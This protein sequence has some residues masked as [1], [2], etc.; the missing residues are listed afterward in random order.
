[1]YYLTAKSHVTCKSQ[2]YSAM[3]SCKVPPRHL[4]CS[5]LGESVCRS[6]SRITLQLDSLTIENRVTLIV[7]IHITA[8]RVIIG[9]PR[10]M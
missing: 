9:I 4:V 7:T 1:M 2:L 10:D 3:L 5:Q 8:L 6:R